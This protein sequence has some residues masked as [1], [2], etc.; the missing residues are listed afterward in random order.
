MN[1][2]NDDNDLKHPAFHDETKEKQKWSWAEIKGLLFTV[3]V[4][5]GLVA[6]MLC[7][8]YLCI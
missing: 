3:A 2:F 8:V 4:I 5:A 1:M 6:Y 7:C